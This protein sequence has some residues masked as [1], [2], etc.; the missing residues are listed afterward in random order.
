MAYLSVNDDDEKV[1]KNK[2]FI[3]NHE[4]RKKYRKIKFHFSSLKSAFEDSLVAAIST[5]LNLLM[6]KTII[7]FMSGTPEECK[8][9]KPRAKKKSTNHL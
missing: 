6:P 9:R 4:K 5:C 2:K 3:E 8:I 7:F 1:K